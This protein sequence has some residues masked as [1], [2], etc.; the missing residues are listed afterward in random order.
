MNSLD[1]LLVVIVL[2]YAV[3]G[4]VQGFVVNLVATIGLLVGAGG[5]ILLVPRLLDSGSSGSLQTSLLALGL[6]IGAAAIG[7][8]VGTYLGTDLR[9]GIRSGSARHVDAVG[10]G[11]LSIVTV[12][13]AT[14][15]LGYSVSGTSIPYLSSAARQSAIL[16]EV[17]AIMPERAS[18]ALRA[19]NR[20]LDANLF[21]R[22][23]DPFT[24]EQIQAVGP[25]DD[26]IL[27]EAGVREAGRSVVKVTGRAVCGRGIEGSG[28]VYGPGRVMTNAHVV[29]GVSEPFVDVDGREVPGQ[30]VVFDADLDIAVIAT[31]D[32]GVPALDF[33]E[34]GAPG[35]SAAV[36]GYPLNGPFDARSARIRE[37]MTL[38]SPDIY[39]RGE[40][41]RETFSIRGLVRSGNSGGPLV[42]TEGDVLGVIFAAS[43][44]DSAT[45]Y[46]VTA[47]AAA[48]N[49]AEG[50]RSSTAVDT[51]G[52]A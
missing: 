47:E 8:A 52:C 50:L 29:A 3:S 49:A 15:A 1:V 19:F 9:G 2:A 27:S 26:V 37:Q 38:R 39:E 33:D 40:V 25:P 46:A 45:G 18:G 7:Q 4:Y 23:I 20:T 42:S 12:L 10:G 13:V 44:S 36:L 43:I 48:E 16:G 6:V 28:F 31:S 14:W 41:L 17:D 11:A 32:L 5:A 30:V 51:G 35:Q 21:P 22:Y 34:S 24:P